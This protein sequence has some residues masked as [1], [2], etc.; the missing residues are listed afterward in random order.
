MRALSCFVLSA[1]IFTRAAA[2]SA[3]SPLDPASAQAR[4]RRAYEA[5]QKK[6]W[7]EARLLL[8]DLWQRARTYDVAASLGQVEYQL[9]NHAPAAEYMAFAVEHIPPKE[10]PANVERYRRALG[11]LRKLVGTL[12][13]SLNPPEA[14]LFVD[15]KPIPAGAGEIF[16]A[17]GVHVLEARVPP[18]RGSSTKVA[19]LAGEER[20]VELDV[21][22]E[23]AEA[24]SPIDTPEP[25]PPPE[26]ESKRERNL[27]P[28]YVGGG[29]IALGVGAAVGFG[30]AADDATSEASELRRQIGP[31][32]CADGSA[33][34][35]DCRAAEDA[36]DR[37]H[38]Y[39]TL[40]TVGIGVA[41]ASGL[42]TLGYVLFW[43]DPADER[44]AVTLRP[45]FAV[46]AESG[47]VSMTGSF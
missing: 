41:V 29:L 13:I 25:T 44:A 27:I 16:V 37:Q 14:A 32:G 9:G 12:R 26:P 17:P 46:G 34:P 7:A 33:E 23:P 39:A 36:L 5:I 35:A 24:V 20:S 1:L 2:V 47:S 8:L 40:S 10:S 30:I 45:Q 11:E 22:T 43:P 15:G 6:Q 31:T 18:H 21:A 19:L 38:D 4:Y 3:E 28:V 42:A